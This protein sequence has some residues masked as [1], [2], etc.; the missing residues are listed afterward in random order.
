M[1]RRIKSNKTPG[2][3]GVPGELLKWLDAEN[4]RTL[5]EAGFACLENGSMDQ[6][7]MKAIVAFIRNKETHHHWQIIDRSLYY[8]LVTRSLLHWLKNGWMPDWIQC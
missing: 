2:H 8:V 7:F 6:E 4:K 5:L 3:D 1:L